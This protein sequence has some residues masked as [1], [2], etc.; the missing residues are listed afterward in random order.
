MCRLS[1][2]LMF[3]H[4]SMRVPGK[5]DLDHLNCEKGQKKRNEAALVLS[6]G[7]SLAHTIHSPCILYKILFSQNMALKLNT[8]FGYIPPFPP[9]VN[10]ILY[11]KEK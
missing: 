8:L 11:C 2:F 4:E 1:I 7:F 3:C 9:A 5:L 10:L 6:P